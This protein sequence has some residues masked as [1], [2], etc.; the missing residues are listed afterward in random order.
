MLLTDA[1]CISA[2][3]MFTRCSGLSITIADLSS[4][5]RRMAICTAADTLHYLPVCD[6][7]PIWGSASSRC[8][9]FFPCSEFFRGCSLDH[10]RMLTTGFTFS[11]R[12]EVLA[13]GHPSG[14]WEALRSFAFLHDVR[15]FYLARIF[16]TL[17]MSDVVSRN[18]RTLGGPLQSDEQPTTFRS[19]LTVP[20]E[21]LSTFTRDTRGEDIV[22]CEMAA[23][24]EP[25][26][27]VEFA[28]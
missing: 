13:E 18:T 10:R 11:G 22:C 20:T 28:V 25:P 7:C 19:T 4:C 21:V 6:L 1:R 17:T 26:C 5:E 23:R 16:V 24:H 15:C 27:T 3:Q 2:S 9:L 12:S 14:D 8:P